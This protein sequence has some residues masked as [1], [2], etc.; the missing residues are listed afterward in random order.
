MELLFAAKL[1]AEL[2]LYFAFA[3]FFPALLSDLPVTIAAPALLFLAGFFTY[4]LQRKAGAPQTGASRPALRKAGLLAYLPLLLPALCLY[5]APNPLQLVLL[6]PP[7]AYL[8]QTAR[9]KNYQITYA[10]QH[11]RFILGL[12]ILP[13][14]FVPV[15]FSLRFS[16]LALFERRS[17]PFAII[18]LLSGILSL[19]LARHQK[20]TLDNPRFKLINFLLLALCCLIC[21]PLSSPLLWSYVGSGF[22]LLYEK[23][24]Q[25]LI[26]LLAS[27]IAL[28]FW[29]FARLLSK[30]VNRTTPGQQSGG[31][32]LEP[33]FDLPW[34]TAGQG[35]TPEWLRIIFIAAAVILFF[36]AAY[37]LFKRLSGR[38]LKDDGPSG[39]VE[40]RN[41]IDA[42]QGPRDLFAPAA[43]GP[44]VR[45][46]YR[47]FLRLCQKNGLSL[48]KDQ[49]SGDILEA[50]E[51]RL[52]QK[53]PE[54]GR[55]RELYIEARYDEEH[56]G[57]RGKESKELYQSIKKGF[58]EKR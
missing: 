42:D 26:L 21:L 30:L 8:I 47:K 1:M 11:A 29:L 43:D 28:P 48:R 13:F 27:V 39:V 58:S 31:T 34:D 24:I 15:F 37:Q 36:V 40:T 17:L 22:G 33:A 50:A 45:F 23:L 19:R 16:N 51:R 25:P 35:G 38:R 46:Y 3:N 52:P 14:T 56:F 55:L 7:W 5:F 32:D 54:L 20:E 44:A 6:L 41:R 18:Y 10:G 57:G 9:Q 2:A 12:K 53:A 4:A 49:T